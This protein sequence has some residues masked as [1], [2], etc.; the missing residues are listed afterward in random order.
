MKT[1]NA[2][3]RM[4]LEKVA[5]HSGFF[6]S[7]MSPDGIDPPPPTVADV[8]IA[9]DQAMSHDTGKEDQ[10]RSGAASSACS[11]SASRFSSSPMDSSFLS[12]RKAS[13]LSECARRICGFCQ[14]FA[15]GSYIR[16]RFRIEWRV[17]HRKE[18]KYEHHVKAVLSR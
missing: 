12:L 3:R 5:F 16:V 2:L 11:D 7:N 9:L 17:S 13:P 4:A 18:R 8:C 6:V 15:S 14:N 10:R 1:K